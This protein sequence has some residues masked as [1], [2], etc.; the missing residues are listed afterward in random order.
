MKTNSFYDQ[1]ERLD[2]IPLDQWKKA[3][4]ELSD[5]L[6][7]KLEGRI[8]N[9]PL[10]KSALGCPA[11]E[12][13]SKK[14][15]DMLVNG[16]CQ[17]PAHVSLT[18]QLIRNANNEKDRLYAEWELQNNGKQ[19]SEEEVRHQLE[20][21]KRVSKTSLLMAYRIAEHMVS[22]NEQLLALLR[23][24]REETDRSK[25]ARKMNISIVEVMALERKLQKR[26]SS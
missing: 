13:L 7:D 21:D 1:Q 3:F 9:G 16:D 10:S 4:N 18:T 17:W 8:R 19:L 22:D 24:M 6:T 20:V 25:I 5:Y 2:N 14:A 12:Y 23:A 26:L 15:Y 11:V